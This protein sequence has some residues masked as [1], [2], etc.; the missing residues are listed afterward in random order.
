[1]PAPVLTSSASFTCPH[2]GTGTLATGLTISALATNVTINGH[3]PIL[4]GATIGGF[5]AALGCTFQLSGTPTPCV[6]FTL[7]LPSGAA[8]TIGGKPVYTAADAAAIAL[9]PSTGNGTPGL[10]V[11]E[12]QALVLA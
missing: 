3:P 9:I 8:F 4:A 7:P 12:S 2:G 10:K 5:T 11:S 6:G 1:M